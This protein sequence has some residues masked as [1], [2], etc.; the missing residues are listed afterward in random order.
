MFREIWILFGI[1]QWSMET[2]I[3][4]NCSIKCWNSP[5]G[6][7]IV[8]KR[9][10]SSDKSLLISKVKSNETRPCFSRSSLFQ[11]QESSMINHTGIV[12]KHYVREKKSPIVDR[13]HVYSRWRRLIQL[14]R[15]HPYL[16]KT[17]WTHKIRAVN[18]NSHKESILFAVSLF[19]FF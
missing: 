4:K 7:T 13:R 11:T 14:H 17:M 8:S 9:M 18:G 16:Q 2:C 6:I 3:E 10:I 15:H 1:I 19:L 5:F 12:C